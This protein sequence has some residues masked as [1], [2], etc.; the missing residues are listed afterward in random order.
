MREWPLGMQHSSR[1]QR[2]LVL[3]CLLPLNVMLTEYVGCRF[4]PLHC[5]ACNYDI[6]PF[7]NMQELHNLVLLA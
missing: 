4:L 3:G 7:F 1:R 2:L 5:W 6:I